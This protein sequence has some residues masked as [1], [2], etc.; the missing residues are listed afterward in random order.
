M[1]SL[2]I[3]PSGYAQKWRVKAPKRPNTIKQPRHI[4]PPII[5][6]LQN[7]NSNKRGL[8][9]PVVGQPNGGRLCIAD[10]PSTL[11][12]SAGVPSSLTKSQ[13]TQDS[14]ESLYN[15]TTV[16]LNFTKAKVGGHFP[17]F[18]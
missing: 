16:R 17:D 11:F 18:D 12:L 5:S 15:H 6:N 10:V 13:I 8:K 2:T 1:V 9:I 4:F 14:P 3:C 7:S